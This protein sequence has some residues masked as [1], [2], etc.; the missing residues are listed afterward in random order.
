MLEAATADRPMSFPTPLARSCL[1]IHIAKLWRATLTVQKG[2]M[3][4]SR[5][6]QLAS[7]A[8]AALAATFPRYADLLSNDASDWSKVVG[9]SRYPIQAAPGWIF[10]HPEPLTFC[11]AGIKGLQT[12]LSLATERQRLLRCRTTR[13]SWIASGSCSSSFLGCTA[14]AC[15]SSRASNP[16]PLLAPRNGSV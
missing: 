9:Q 11:Q 12:L 15:K 7:D 13:I 10:P 3:V 6:V 14:S 4:W 1:V 8:A 16:R 2:R 5:R